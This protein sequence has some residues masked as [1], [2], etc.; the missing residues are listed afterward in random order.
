MTGTNT[1][2]P[3][4]C[5]CGSGRTGASCCEPLLAGTRRATTALELM[6]SRYTA[7]VRGNVEYL[8]AT[9]AAQPT[10]LGDA[11]RRHHIE[12]FTRAT[13]WLGLE[14]IATERGRARDDD[15]VVEFVAAG[16]AR[17]KPFRQHERSRFR[18]G[19]DGGWLYV[20]GELR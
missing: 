1:S 10:G 18:R 2:A 13:L 12:L 3:K 20:D 5:P 15:G 14:I 16:V 19:S 9:H 8:L 4:P 11:E 17:G 6:R 7:Y